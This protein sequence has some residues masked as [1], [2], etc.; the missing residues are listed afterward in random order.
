MNEDCVNQS[1]EI[2]QNE[3]RHVRSCIKQA[4]EHIEALQQE[5]TQLTARLINLESKCQT[6]IIELKDC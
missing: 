4:N 6:I 1:E 3:I 2:L 5:K